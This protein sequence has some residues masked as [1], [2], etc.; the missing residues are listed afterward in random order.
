MNDSNYDVSVSTP[1]IFETKPNFK[2]IEGEVVFHAIAEKYFIVANRRNLN[3]DNF[4]DLRIDRGVSV[5]NQP[6]FSLRSLTRE[7]CGLC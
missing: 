1:I 4:Y 7:E 5:L 6:E 3:G 2:F